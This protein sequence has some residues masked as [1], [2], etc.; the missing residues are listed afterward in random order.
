MLIL[1]P[2]NSV[3]SRGQ[4]EFAH[5]W[6]QHGI[7]ISLSRAKK[8]GLLKATVKSYSQP[9]WSASRQKHPVCFMFSICNLYFLHTAHFHTSNCSLQLPSKLQ[10]SC[11][12]K[13][14]TLLHNVRMEGDPRGLRSN[15]NP[16]KS[17]IKHNHHI[18]PVSTEAQMKYKVCAY[19]WNQRCETQGQVRC[20]ACSL[21]F[22]CSKPTLQGREKKTTNQKPTAPPVT[23]SLRSKIL[24]LTTHTRIKNNNNK[25]HNKIPG[26]VQK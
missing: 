13:G 19:I 18:H 20:T 2:L 21:L 11:S 12:R 25:K 15:S 10:L 9:S 26:P 6:T 16:R 5:T 3:L 14:A 8:Q 1:L 7:S 4:H 22:A 24:I 17:F 23:V